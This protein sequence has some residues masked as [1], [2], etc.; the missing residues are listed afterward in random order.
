[1]R[2]EVVLS[3]RLQSLAKM[4]TPGCRVCDVGCD[5]GYLSIYLIRK[6]ISPSVI[7]MDVR[8]GP[9]SRCEEHVQEYGLE[10][11]IQIRLSDGLAKL[12][13]GEADEVV[14]AGMGGRLMMKIL[15]E[16]RVAAQ[17]LHALI[18]QPQSELKAFR[19]FLRKEGYRIT[20]EDMVEEDGKFYPMMKVVYVGAAAEDARVEKVAQ[21]AVCKETAESVYDRFG[22]Y[23]LKSRN[24]VLLRFLEYRRGVLQSIRERIGTSDAVERLSEIDSE[25][26]DIEAAVKYYENRG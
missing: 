10:E 7:A 14:C 15:Q 20:A 1:M 22:E 12:K 16:G 5:H 3:A 24:P 2:K 23:L 26:R 19:E 4:V 13:P 17:K 9:L 6:Q 8:T 11:Y 21:A 18:L 25:F